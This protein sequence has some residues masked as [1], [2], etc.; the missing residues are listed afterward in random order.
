MRH[1][2]R[3]FVVLLTVLSVA[4]PGCK[5]PKEQEGNFTVNI[6]PYVGTQPLALST[7]YADGAGLEFYV[8]KLKFYLSH[9]KLVK[10]DN[11]EVEIAAAAFFNASDNNWTS[12][13]AKVDA[14]TYKGIKF[15]VGLDATQNATD[16]SSYGEEEALGPKDDM[17]WEWQKHRFIIM[18]G[19]ADTAGQSFS[20]SVGLAYHIGTDATYREVILTGNDI[21]VNEGD[22]AIN[23]NVD[24]LKVF[25]NQPAP[26]NMITQAATQSEG[27]DLPIALQF[28]DQFS[29]AFTYSE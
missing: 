27:G 7:T 8:G 26:V 25:L 3:F 11:S 29:K 18:E 22:K 15:H 21:V 23:L 19:R 5:D 2:G 1:C 4:L 16:P 14:G 13:S 17:Y 24:L 10:A 20:S 6:I 12:F 28:A 9:V